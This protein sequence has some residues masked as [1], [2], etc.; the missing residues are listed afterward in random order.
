MQETEIL[1]TIN[2]LWVPAQRRLRSAAKGAA[3]KS[4]AHPKRWRVGSGGFVEVHTPQTMM[5]GPFGMHLYWAIHMIH[6]VI[7]KTADGCHKLLP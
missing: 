7:P 5:W 4:L 6:K 1:Q 2:R 3:L